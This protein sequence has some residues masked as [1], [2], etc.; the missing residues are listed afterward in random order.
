MALDRVV[1]LHAERDVG[2]NALAIA[3][4]QAWLIAVHEWHLPRLSV[5]LSAARRARRAHSG[6]L[7]G[8]GN[9]VNR[10]SAENSEGS[11][12]RERLRGNRSLTVPITSDG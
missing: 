10:G 9:F 4:R 12:K 11:D 2:D 3:D 1:V 6:E 5:A 8:R 7:A